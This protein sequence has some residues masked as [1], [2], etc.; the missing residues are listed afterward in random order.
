M[1]SILSF[2]CRSGFSY[3]EEKEKIF[4]PNNKIQNKNKKSFQ[5]TIHTIY[6]KFAFFGFTSVKNSHNL[7]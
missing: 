5:S 7:I 4:V 6:I 2:E 1:A 3:A